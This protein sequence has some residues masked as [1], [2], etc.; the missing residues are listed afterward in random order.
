MT[1]QRVAFGTD[2]AAPVR[3]GGRSGPAGPEDRE[4]WF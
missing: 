1:R 4:I 3:F 2:L